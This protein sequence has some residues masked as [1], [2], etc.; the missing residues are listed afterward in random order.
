MSMNPE[1]TPPP[2][3][4]NPPGLPH[5]ADVC[6]TCE[7]H[8]CDGEGFIPGTREA[9]CPCE[10]HEDPAVVQA[11]RDDEIYQRLKEEGW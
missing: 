8:A 6:E 7:A 5:E 3:W 9:C 11:M 1:D 4:Y 2:S 10:A